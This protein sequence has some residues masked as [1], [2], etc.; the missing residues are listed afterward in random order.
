MKMF[1]YYEKCKAKLKILHIIFSTSKTYSTLDQ[2]WMECLTSFNFKM[3]VSTSN[4]TK[5]ADWETII[6]VL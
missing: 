3:F 2:Y 5:T 6:I 4:Q 1:F